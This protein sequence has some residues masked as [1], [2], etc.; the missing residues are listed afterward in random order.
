MG[1]FTLVAAGANRITRYSSNDFTNIPTGL[2]AGANTLNIAD[3]G[4]LLTTNEYFAIGLFNPLGG[5]Y[6]LTATFTFNLNVN[7]IV[8]ASGADSYGVVLENSKSTTADK[9]VV[10]KNGAIG[11][12][13]TGVYASA[14]TNIDNF[15]L[16]SSSG[17][18]N[19]NG[20]FALVFDKW[21]PGSNFKPISV[22]TI[23]NNLGAVI[24]GDNSGILFD[25]F[26]KIVINNKGIIS[27]G[28]ATADTEGAANAIRS[29]DGTVVLTN[30]L[31]A[32]IDG[33][34]RTG[35]I[36]S[37]ITNNGTMS[38]TINAHMYT[39][40]SGFEESG[41]TGFI[42]Y[43]RDGTPAKSD[44]GDKHLNFVTET[45]ITVTN[46]GIIE[47]T[48]N[49]RQDN[50]N[51]I[52]VA[53]DLTSGKDKVTNSG[54]I[55][56]QIEMREGN[57]IL[58]NAI[59]GKIYGDVYLGS[60]TFYHSIQAYA[61]DADILTNKGYIE[62]DVQTDMG[63]DTVTNNGEITGYLE[64]GTGDYGAAY[65]LGE[66]Y[67]ILTNTGTIRGYVWLG[68]GD[69]TVTNS[70]LM[71]DGLDTSAWAPWDA[72]NGFRNDP[73]SIF[74]N[75]KDKV[76]NTGVIRGGVFTGH[77]AD[78][79]IN[80]GAVAGDIGT[81]VGATRGR[82]SNP[83]NPF[84]AVDQATFQADD[85][86]IVTNSGSVQGEI[87]TG[88]GADTIT[89]SGVVQ[90]IYSSSEYTENDGVTPRKY[91]DQ[92]NPFTYVTSTLPANAGVFDKDKV[93]NSGTVRDEIWTGVGDDLITNAIT[94]RVM[95]NGIFGARGEDVINNL[96]YVKN[97]V[98]GG[99]GNDTITN[100]GFIG[101]NVYLGS[102][103]GE[104]N[105]LI[106]T[107]T[108]GGHVAGDYGEFGDVLAEGT[109]T[110][111]NSGV[112]L[113]GIDL[114]DGTDTVKN[115][116]AGHIEGVIHLG[117]GNDFFIGNASSE[118][119]IDGDGGDN[120]NF[121]AG[122]DHL[123]YALIALGQEVDG[124]TDTI[125]GGVGIDSIDGS[126]LT[127]DVNANLSVALAQTITF[128][129]TGL[130]DNTD[131]LKNFENISTGSGNDTIIGTAGVNY[132]DA[133]DGNNV[134][135]GGGGQDIMYSGS[136]VD[137]FVFNFITD[138]AAGAGDI[139]GGFEA[140]DFLEINFVALANLSQSNNFTPMVAGFAQWHTTVVGGNTVVEFNTDADAAAEVA[141]YL[142]G[143]TGVISDTN[144]I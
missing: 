51:D 42:D 48:E 117:G 20:G 109:N 16:I 26:G 31:G 52:Q 143:Y 102:G 122:D 70:G 29:W 44:A 17:D 59:T 82:S 142:A 3:S 83:D 95:G 53:L 69:D 119:I 67:D 86:D 111:E 15:G 12:D 5:T 49:W 112:I 114:G 11:G 85:N 37:I 98:H 132:I 118:T 9:I 80:S 81:G 97:D 105:K 127:I 116:G 54:K 125:D 129:N 66:D 121:G 134:I 45:A 141:I 6:P 41:L 90:A 36:N 4:R 55:F 99:G 58:D 68:L 71:N 7:G 93:T 24:A 57:D 1:T 39:E 107:K 136:G 64:M 89:N 13:H 138:S 115:L 28:E 104:T 27:G 2:P 18:I 124:D 113:G 56:G 88:L 19:G 126:G 137:T 22:V 30:S 63:K 133:G 21:A 50:G 120:Y 78:T 61:N 74:D 92:D 79:V 139:I 87:W 14:V 135:A 108:I 60:G 32:V 128:S 123:I 106:N 25:T 110:I 72:V 65:Q 46:T 91:Y 131:N 84:I 73:T 38:G 96:G 10:G 130:F 33:S 100:S 94:G 75:D 101:F 77:G 43:D 140:Q 47:G 40:V 23:N 103:A 8:S 35:W 34:I 144:F 62:G 76:T